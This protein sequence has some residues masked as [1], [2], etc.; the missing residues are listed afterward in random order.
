MIPT[1]HILTISCPDTIGIVFHVTGFLFERGCNII[2]SQQF[3]DETTGRF[4]MRVHFDVPA[5]QTIDLVRSQF[6]QIAQKFSMEL[7][8]LGGG[9]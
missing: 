8:Y 7:G 1:D 9:N 6:E 2:D 3:G 4:F 5:N